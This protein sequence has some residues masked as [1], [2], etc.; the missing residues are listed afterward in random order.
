MWS[1]EF[2]FKCFAYGT[3]FSKLQ[4]HNITNGM[5]SELRHWAANTI[6]S[7][8]CL[9]NQLFLDKLKVVSNENSNPFSTPHSAITSH[10]VSIARSGQYL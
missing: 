8:L 6:S 3:S 5:E 10:L 7:P 2:P 1:V 9:E 4:S